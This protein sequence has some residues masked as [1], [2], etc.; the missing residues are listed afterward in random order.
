[1]HDPELK[2]VLAD[3]A[4]DLKLIRQIMAYQAKIEIEED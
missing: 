2:L 4:S 1:M 3:I